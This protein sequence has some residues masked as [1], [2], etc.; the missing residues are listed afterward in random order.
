MANQ[1][2]TDQLDKDV[3]TQEAQS[4]TWT[5]ANGRRYA[6]SELGHY[7]MPNDEPEVQR[8]NQQHWML[9]EARGG[10][11]TLAPL[12][13]KNAL[14][15]LDIGCGSGIWCLQMAEDHP[16]AKMV[17]ADVS[18]VQPANKPENVEWIVLDFENGKWPFPENH[19]DLIHLSLVHGCVTDW[20]KTLTHIMQYV[21]P[22]GFIEHQEFAMGGQYI[23]EQSGKRVNYSALQDP[24]A[25]ARW[26]GLMCEAADKR[27]RTL[28]LGPKLKEMQERAGLVGVEE[29]IY[30]LAI[31]TWPE[32]NRQKLVGTQFLHNV[33]TGID[34]F[35]MVLFTTQL[36]WSVEATKSF[37]E[38][39]KKDLR[40]NS[41][42]KMMDLY[43]VYGQ[44]P[45]A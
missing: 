27:G 41:L 1:I 31:G 44:K 13:T 42:R 33:L 16:N 37:I 30:P 2:T 23:L 32:D 35:T 4:Y 19:F 5:Y 39:C 12:P 40:D 14:N 17:G 11:I 36:G 10:S 45:A 34:G 29:A 9:T 22:G 38:D 3:R 7:Y 28:H 15:I 20:E 43:V 26:P 21:K 25:F 6:S 8:L 18:P 24:P